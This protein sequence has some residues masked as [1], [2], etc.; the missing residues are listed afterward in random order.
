[1][2]SGVDLR[3]DTTN[4]HK[5]KTLSER[6]RINPEVAISQKDCYHFG[7]IHKKMNKYL[8]KKIEQTKGGAYF[9]NLI[10]IANEVCKSKPSEMFEEFTELEP[11]EIAKV[12]GWNDKKETLKYIKDSIKDEEF[13]HALLQHDMTGFLAECRM[14][15]CSNFRF[16]EG[17][18][19]PTSWS[20]HGGICTIFYVY[21]ES[22]GELVEKLKEESE[23]LF[24]KQLEDFK[25][26]QSTSK[27]E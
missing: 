15:E 26:E 18:E 19:K 6:F 3:L 4:K 1:M 21:A 27:A 8:F 20:V 22:I 5:L 17:K 2:S 11:S 25:L 12:L 23:K 9:E 7:L 10:L 14:P 16:T 13:A 24:L